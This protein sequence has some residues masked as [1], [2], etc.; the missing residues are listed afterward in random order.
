[1]NITR[2]TNGLAP[3]LLLGLLLFVLQEKGRG[4]KTTKRVPPSVSPD[5][6]VLATVNGDPITLADFQ[7]RFA[8]AGLKP[9]KEAELQVKEEFLNRLIERKMMLREAQRR[10]IKVGLPEINKRIETLRVEHGQGHEGHAGRPWGST[11]RN[12]SPISGKT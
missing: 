2:I 7:D 5:I 12:G 9:E 8:R 10:R 6:K 11:L 4:R 3:V 1:M